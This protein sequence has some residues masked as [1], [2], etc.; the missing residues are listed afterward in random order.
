MARKKNIPANEP[1]DLS[2]AL[3]WVVNQKDRGALL[4]ASKDATPLG[5]VLVVRAGRRSWGVFSANLRDPS[6]TAGH[7]LQWSAI[8]WAK[9][10]GCVDY[11]LGGYR[12]GINTGPPS[13]KRGFCRAVVEFSPAYRHPLNRFLC[14]VLDFVAKA[15]TKWRTP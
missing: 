9:E 8:R 14:S 3:R 15:R 2:H 6:V 12:E 11:D 7:L 13:F 4:L 1:D 5:G 10:H